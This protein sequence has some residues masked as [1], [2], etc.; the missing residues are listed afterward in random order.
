MTDRNLGTNIPA[1]T[2]E[3]YRNYHR[4][5]RRLTA[6][7]FPAHHVLNTPLRMKQLPR[8]KPQN[9][10]DTWRMP[11][12]AMWSRVALVRTAVLEKL[13]TS[14]IRVEKISELGTMFAVTS[15]RSELR[16]KNSFTLMMEVLIRLSETS[17]FPR[18]TRRYI[19]EYSILNSHRR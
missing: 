17:V 10:N 7:T 13:I 16:R 1:G 12:S 3:R 19:H 9:M 2:T 6:D 5:S 15:K 4:Y 18:T 11:P 8:M 14:T